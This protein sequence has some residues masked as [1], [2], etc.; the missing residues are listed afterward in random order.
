MAA[1]FFLGSCGEIVARREVIVK[2]LRSIYDRFICCNRLEDK[3]TASKYDENSHRERVIEFNK[4]L[5]Y[6]RDLPEQTI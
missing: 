3:V 4:N 6:Q 1:L 2:Q 5:L